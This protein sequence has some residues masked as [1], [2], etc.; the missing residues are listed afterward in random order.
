M[1][2]VL[3]ASCILAIVA[4]AS[5]GAAAQ[6]VLD[7]SKPQTGKSRF[8]LNSDMTPA[9]LGVP[10][11]AKAKPVQAAARTPACGEGC[12]MEQPVLPPEQHAAYGSDER[13]GR[14]RSGAVP[15]F[16]AVAGAKAVKQVED[17]K[18]QQKK[19]FRFRFGRR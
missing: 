12:K 15:V 10:P 9:T 17:V 16:A 19:T 3:S 8:V 5:S 18:A 2:H 7:L 6:S 13:G 11:D 1:R 14:S 4:A